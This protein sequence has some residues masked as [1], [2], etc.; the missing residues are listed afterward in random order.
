MNIDLNDL[1]RRLK[2]VQDR[3]KELAGVPGVESISFS[4]TPELV[5]ELI[6]RL[7]RAEEVT[8][9]TRYVNVESGGLYD[10][11]QIATLEAD[12]ANRLVVYRSVATGHVWAR[13]ES[14][15]FAKFVE[16]IAIETVKETS[17]V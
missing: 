2:A 15:F 17:H 4:T 11:K 13:P 12:G 6:A 1:K 7:E 10:V 16:V 5:L 8:K 3:V 9:S 14:E